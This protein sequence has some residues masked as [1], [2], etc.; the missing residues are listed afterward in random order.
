MGAGRLRLRRVASGLAFAAL[1]LSGVGIVTWLRIWRAGCRERLERADAIVVFGA[2]VWPSG[3]ST[4]LRL[5]TLHGAE[6]YRRGLAP[7]VVC[8][9]GTSGATSE[10]AVMAALLREQGVPVSALVLDESGVT[11]RATLRSI[12]T[13]AAG[14]RQTILAVSS[15][16]HV[17]RIVEEARRHGII[18][19]AAP[20]R[21]SGPA[22]GARDALRL[23]LSDARQYAREVIAVW[24]Y[25]LS[26]GGAAGSEDAR[27]AR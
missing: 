16:Y 27:R 21:R 9:G 7:R 22:R 1:L 13:L 8:S 20:A 23:R 19:L 24:A 10:P 11:T 26:S 2:A 17:F 4:T 15:P 5:R 6:L 25:R 14:T 12:A 3:P 18:A